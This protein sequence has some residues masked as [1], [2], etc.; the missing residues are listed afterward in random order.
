MSIQTLQRERAQL[1]T[2]VQELAAQAQTTM[3]SEAELAE[4]T[5]LETKFAALSSQIDT[6][7]RAERIAMAAAVPVDSVEAGK[8]AQLDAT[9]LAQGAGN[10][11]AGS[12]YF[13]Q[14]KDHAAH[15][16]HNMSVFSG[17]IAALKHSPGNLAAGAEFARKTM[18]TNGVGDGVAMALSSVNASG[19]AVLVPTNL[20]QTVIERLIPNAVVRSMGPLLLPLN[21]GNLTMPRIAGGAVAGYIG[22]DNDAPVSQQSFD[23]VQLVA[24][25]LACLVPIGNDLIRFAGID[26]RVDGLIVEDTAFSMANAEDVAFIRGD[27]TNSTPKGLRNWCLAQNVLKA[28]PTANLAGQE[29]VQAIMNDAGRCVLALRR[30]NVRLRKPG[31]LMHPDSVQFLGDLLTSTGNKVFPEIADGMF[32]GYPIG[33]TTEIPTNLTSGGA[34]G[35]GSEIYFVDFAEMVIGE[36]MNLSVAISMDATYTDPVTGNPVS[37]FQRDLTLIRIITENDF[38]PR[39]AEAIAVL[40]GVTWYR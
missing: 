40:D 4:F 21:N 16:A 36:S 34:T 26:Q 15:A 33:I 29:L 17:I 24:K 11:P 22:R 19:G 28:T 6:A 10:S 37:A 27:G 32:R 9:A 30:S 31:W 38:G 1:N 20:A 23:D 12:P 13:A 25:K 8:E 39:H 3:L 35:N 5:E 2:R 18:R 7:L 14:P